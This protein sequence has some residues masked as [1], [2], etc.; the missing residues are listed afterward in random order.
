MAI[1]ILTYSVFILLVYF[2]ITT[3]PI[4]IISGLIGRISN[5]Y[6]GYSVILPISILTWI[7]IDYLWLI[8]LHQ[9][10]TLIALIITLLLL[11]IFYIPAIKET[12]TSD[13]ILL[14]NAQIISVIILIIFLGYNGFL[15]WY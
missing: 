15:S 11:Y 7:G 2:R 3:F 6:F 5:H 14:N 9:H 12:L 13:S 4:A 8:I 10:I 1:T